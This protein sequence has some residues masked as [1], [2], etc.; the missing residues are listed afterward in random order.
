MNKLSNL[1]LTALGIAF[2][3]IVTSFIA[4]P[5][6]SFGYINIGDAVILLFSTIVSPISAFFIGGIGSFLADLMLAPQYALFTFVIK[7]IEGAVAC[8]LLHR[9]SKKAYGFLVGGLIVIIGYAITDIILSGQVY[10]AFPSIGFN[11]IQCVICI[12]IALIGKPFLQK[13]HDKYKR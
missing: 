2:V 6:G 13:L 7:G 4:F 12:I 11:S 9:F 1:L 8:Y 3:F 5:I 10:M